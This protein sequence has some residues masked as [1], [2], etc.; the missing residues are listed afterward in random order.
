M[1]C[2]LA[3]F[4][5]V[6]AATIYERKGWKGFFKYFVLPIFLIITFILIYYIFELAIQST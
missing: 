5:G 6:I 2:G 1:N 3:F 4:L